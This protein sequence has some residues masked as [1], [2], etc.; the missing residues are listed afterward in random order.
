MK[1]VRQGELVFIKVDADF[2]KPGEIQILS[3]KPDLVIREGELTG[4]K[5]IASA[6]KLYEVPI[7]LR[8]DLHNAQMLLESE[9]DVVVS[10]NE[11]KVAELEKGYTLIRIQREYDEERDSLISD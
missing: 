2:F 5:H 6:G 4:H 1:A 3:L 9:T 8:S 11:H 10:H 7:W